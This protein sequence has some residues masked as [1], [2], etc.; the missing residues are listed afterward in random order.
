[1]KKLIMGFALIALVVIITGCPKPCVEAN[2]SFAAT[3][4]IVPDIDSIKIGDTLFLTSSFST[5][6]IDQRT[7]RTVDYSDANDIESTLSI[8]EL[9]NNDSTPEGSVYNFK[10]YSE[11]GL[12]YNATD[13]PNPET[14]QQLKYLQVGN[15]YQIKIGLIPQ[16][17]GIFALGIGNGLS[18]Q[19][20]HSSK[21]EKAA[22][23]FTI[24]N[25]A[26]HIYYYQNWRP[27]YHLSASDISKLYCFKV[28]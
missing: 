9:I 17:P 25:T 18:N 12:I 22:F 7:G 19:R 6:L 28:Y 14:V 27:S 8:A 5:S 20:N 3:S 16:K 11:I 21:C 15:T 23:T 10:Y 24:A 1:M 2:Y 4:Q 13:I 26:Q